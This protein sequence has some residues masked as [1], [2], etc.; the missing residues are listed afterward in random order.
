MTLRQLAELVALLVTGLGV[1]A[2]SGSGHAG[3]LLVD[4]PGDTV[5]FSH[6]PRAPLISAQRLAP[7]VSRSATFAVRNT[8]RYPAD[9]VL[10]VFDVTDDEN[11]CLR[12]EAR[13]PG[14]GCESDEGELSD[15]LTVTVSRA[16]PGS[17][18][19][20][21]GEFSELI[22]GVDLG[23]PLAAGATWGLRVTMSLPLEAPNDTMTD[24]TTFGTR[25]VA[26]ST[27]GRSVVSGARSSAEG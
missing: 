18:A 9:L 5:G 15:W 21:S 19:L 17:P 10:S 2:T 27:V 20:W 23:R 11:G 3:S 13:E 14:E 24:T 1:C 26:R 22:G 7:G 25:L 4:V 6:A 8:S 16:A 12:P